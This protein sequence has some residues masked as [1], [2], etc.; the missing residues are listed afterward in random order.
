LS[1]IGGTPHCYYGEIA[2]LRVAK[3]M[4][5]GGK[6]FWGCP[7]Y[8]VWYVIFNFVWAVFVLKNIFVVWFF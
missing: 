8:K 5:N 2:V 6:Q 7:H 1:H 3:T 4:K